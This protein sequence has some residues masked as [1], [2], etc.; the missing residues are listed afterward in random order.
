MHMEAII[1]AIDTAPLNRGLRGVDWLATP[2]N[3]PIT[4]DNGNVALFDWEGGKDYQVHFLFQ[5]RGKEAIT[6]A[7]EAF[8]QMFVEHGAEL[9]FGLVP[10]FRRDVKLLA[11]WIGGK[12]AGKRQTVDG[13][14]E[15]YVLSN[16]MYFKDCPQC[17]S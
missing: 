12:F 16:L 4:F 1:N 15:L 5:S 2:G 14:C 3:V 9:I 17:L 11:R 7:K 6:N 10:D 13:P 8:R